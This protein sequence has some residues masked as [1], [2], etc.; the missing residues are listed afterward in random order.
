MGFS[1]PYDCFAWCIPVMVEHHAGRVVFRKLDPAF[2]FLDLRGIVSPQKMKGRRNAGLF[3]DNL[4]QCF[5]AS[6]PA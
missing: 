1:S 5:S 3:P 6:V 2:C 4:P